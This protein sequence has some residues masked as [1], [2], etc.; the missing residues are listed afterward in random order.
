MSV[1][2]PLVSTANKTVQE[3]DRLLF[4]QSALEWDASYPIETFTL[5]VKHSLVGYIILAQP[6]LPESDDAYI[7]RIGI[8]IQHRRKGYATQMMTFTE[9]YYRKRNA[10]SIVGD[11]S[12][13]NFASQ[14]MFEKL[15]YKHMGEDYYK[16]DTYYKDFYRY[17]K[18][19]G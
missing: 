11:V 13:T 4:G 15:G 17:Y 10:P 19:L 9:S 14:R 16:S 7:V 2:E 8:Y 6:W 18:D 3:Y 5:K 12:K 1:I